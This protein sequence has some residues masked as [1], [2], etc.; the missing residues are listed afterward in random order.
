MNS[1]HPGLE[2]DLADALR[3]RAASVP[4]TPWQP[5]A[6]PKPSSTGAASP[7][8]WRA[9]KP[10]RAGA[11]L[12]AAAAAALAVVV[13][14]VSHGPAAAPPAVS[15]SDT[16]EHLAPGHF[17]YSLS[18][19][20][21]D[22]GERVRSETWQPQPSTG[23]WLRRSQVGN[24]APA[25]ASGRCL[26]FNTL[27]AAEACTLAPGWANP[28][29]EFLAH[30]PRDPAVIAAQLAAAVPGGDGSHPSAYATLTVLRLAARANG[31]PA[32]LSRA[33]QLT[34]ARLV[35]ASAAR[36]LDGVPGTAY[37]APATNGAS[38]VV[39]FDAD[40]TYI[41]SPAESFTRGVAAEAGAPPVKLFP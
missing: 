33:L 13:V 37:T 35:P 36:N 32:D 6:A 22:S 16:P 23:V 41:G 19:S 29:P 34:A 27:S 25:T 18:V 7:I 10:R 8:P 12:V 17:Y 38:V 20:A 2:D 1:E 11:L 3:A 15:I 4:D 31:L 40:G 9:R 39:V 26:S 24:G 14:V 21:D 5:R 30:A 28:T